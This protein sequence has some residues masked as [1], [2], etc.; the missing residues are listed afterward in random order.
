V[1]LKPARMRLATLGLGLA[2]FPGGLAPGSA[3]AAGSA[4]AARVPL[5]HHNSRS[6]TIPFNPL[7]QADQARLREV[8]LYVSSDTGYNW[9][10]VTQAKPS[11]PAFGFKAPRDAEYWF[12]TRTV[13]TK[14]RLYPADDAPVEPNLKVVVDTAPPSIA[15]EPLARR[16]TEAGVRWEV[17]DEHLDLKSLVVEYRPADA[18]AWRTAPTPRRGL[19]GEVTWDAGTVGAVTV[20]ASVSDKAGNTRQAT[21]ELPEGS[22]GESEPSGQAGLREFDPPPPIL[23]VGPGEDDH[24]PFANVSETN[25]GPDIAPAQSPAPAPT[26]APA[27]SPPAVGERMLVAS[28][29][30]NLR[31]AVDDAGQGG[32]AVVELWLTQDS[33]RTWFRSGA[34]PD[35]ISPYPVDLGGEGTFGVNIVA[36]S[37]SGLGDPAPAPGDRPQLIVEVDATPPTVQLDPPVLGTGEH[38]GK[39]SLRWRASD[40]HISERPVVISYR[41]DQPGARWQPI[42]DRIENTGTYVWMPPKNVAPRFHLRVDVVDSL[43]NRSSADTSAGGPIILDRARPRSRII[44]LDPAASPR[45]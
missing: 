24:V 5:V 28:P 10:M 37:A 29:R 39:V 3:D 36:K 33:G 21:V 4:S 20:R 35:R 31:Y 27:A 18:D 9:K 23:P 1:T 13:D 16:G 25:V 30:F 14:G 11:S 41:A 22:L 7:K 2:L 6:F 34:D 17:R 15:L 8:R 43:G 42:T 38:A 26:P 32:P 19:I 45:R 44:G 40:P 12:A